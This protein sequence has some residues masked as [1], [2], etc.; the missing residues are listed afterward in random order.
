M[1]SQSAREKADYDK[2]LDALLD[3]LA[4]MK[5]ELAVCRELSTPDPIELDIQARTLDNCVASLTAAHGKL[6]GLAQYVD[7][8]RIHNAAPTLWELSLLLDDLRGNLL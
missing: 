5:T 2:R 8:C 3:A 6:L 7:N 4:A 1:R